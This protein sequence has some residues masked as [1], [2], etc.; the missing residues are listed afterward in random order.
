MD[1]KMVRIRLSA[2]LDLMPRGAGRYMTTELE[3]REPKI[4]VLAFDISM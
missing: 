1:K 4:W 2:E 3:Y